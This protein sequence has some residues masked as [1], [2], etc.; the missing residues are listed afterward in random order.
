MGDAVG[1][2]TILASAANQKQTKKATTN[3]TGQLKPLPLPLPPSLLTSRKFLCTGHTLQSR[4]RKRETARESAFRNWE[5]A[6]VSKAKDNW[7]FISNHLFI[8]YGCRYIEIL[9]TLCLARVI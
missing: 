1:S 9:S 5:S 4:E 7:N 8:I 6:R 2:S 3:K